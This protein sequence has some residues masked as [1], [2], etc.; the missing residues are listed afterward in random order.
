MDNTYSP[1]DVVV[2]VLF[3]SVLSGDFSLSDTMLMN[4][5]FTQSDNIRKSLFSY[6][7]DVENPFDKIK[8]L[9]GF[10]LNRDN[11]DDETILRGV[12]G[13]DKHGFS[14]L[15]RHAISDE[16][17]RLL[18]SA[19][20]LHMIGADVM[21]DSI[22]RVAGRTILYDAFKSIIEESELS[23]KISEI[24]RVNASGPKKEF[25]N[26]AISVMRNTWS[27]Y[28][29]ASKNGMAEKISKHF[30]EDKLSK[31]TVLR[32]I[33]KESLGPTEDIRPPINFS[34][35]LVHSEL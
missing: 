10:T 26:H 14:F 16:A 27:E 8:S 2:S 1:R 35:V 18:N 24:N 28:P 15:E 31:V 12:R 17:H 4:S 11:N 9:I 21:A 6:F 23:K 19:C 20:A 7:D 13:F 30:G 32:W 22:A 29:K 5:I 3:N 34:L 33:K 25:Y